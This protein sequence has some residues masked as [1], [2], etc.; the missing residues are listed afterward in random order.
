MSFQNLE[1]VIPAMLRAANRV[2]GSPLNWPDVNLPDDATT[3]PATMIPPADVV[4][5]LCRLA[6]NISTMDDN[7]YPA[8]AIFECVA[9]DP[10]GRLTIAGYGLRIVQIPPHALEVIL[11]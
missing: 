11:R 3:M 9:A 5:Q 4:G 10:F 2:F 1:I 6:A 8:G 7:V